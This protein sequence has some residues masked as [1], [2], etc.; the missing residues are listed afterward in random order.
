[1]VRKQQKNL[2]LFIGLNMVPQEDLQILG[3]F[4][5][6]HELE[7]LGGSSQPSPTLFSSTHALIGIHDYIEG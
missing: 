7:I 3:E 6:I 4:E 2:Q 1:M 5:T